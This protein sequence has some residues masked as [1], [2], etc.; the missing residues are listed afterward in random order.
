MLFVI[1]RE[2]P[3]QD[4]E[5]TA[6]KHLFGVISTSV[7]FIAADGKIIHVE[8]FLGFRVYVCARVTAIWGPQFITDRHQMSHSCPGPQTKGRVRK[9]SKSYV[10]FRLMCRTFSM[11][12]IG[13]LMIT[14]KGRSNSKSKIWYELSYRYTLMVGCLEYGQSSQSEIAYC[15]SF[16]FRLMTL[17]FE[18]F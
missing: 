17:T 7:L 3:T 8:G 4:L 2:T 9:G 10:N 6:S 18:C 16:D 13:Q 11:L 15:S 14:F 5:R 1:G 12:N